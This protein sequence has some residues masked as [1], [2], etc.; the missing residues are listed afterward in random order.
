MAKL[1]IA[2]FWLL[3]LAN[4]LGFVPERGSNLLHM[5]ALLAVGVHVVEWLLVGRRLYNGHPERKY[6]LFMVILFGMAHMA[7]D[8]KKLQQAASGDGRE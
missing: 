4:L 6:H 1:L 7:P 2:A 3:E 8:F 5:L